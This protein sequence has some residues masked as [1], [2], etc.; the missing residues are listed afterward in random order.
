MARLAEDKHIDGNTLIM[1]EAETDEERA[2][3]KKWWGLMGLGPES[4]YLA[5]GNTTGPA[6]FIGIRPSA[7]VYVGSDG[8]PKLGGSSLLPGN[9]GAPNR[10]VGKRPDRKV[11]ISVCF[12][13][14]PYLG[15]KCTPP[16]GTNDW[17]D[18]RWWLAGNTPK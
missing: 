16:T 10:A 5:G 12:S 9:V 11:A 2:L 1:I 15:N 14:C 7:G 13:G 8:N 18:C 4:I 17:R 6:V 3:I